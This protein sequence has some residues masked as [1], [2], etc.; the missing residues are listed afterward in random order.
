MP[1]LHFPLTRNGFLLRMAT[2]R[3]QVKRHGRHAWAWAVGLCVLCAGVSIAWGAG[4]SGP[5][6][7]NAAL[8]FV[9]G[10]QDRGTVATVVGIGLATFISEDLACIGSGLLVAQGALSLPLAV[11]ACFVGLYVGDVLLYWAGRLVG[12]PFLR[13]PPFKWLIKQDKVRHCAA[14]LDRRGAAVVFAGRFV[15]GSRFPTFFAAGLLKGH[16][17]RFALYFCLAAAVWTPLLVGGTALAGSAMMRRFTLYSRYSLPLLLGL[18]LIVLLAVRFVVPL[19]THRGRRLLVGFVRSKLYW[20]LWPAWLFNLPV[21]AHCIRLG[22]R[23]GS[24]TAFTAANP[25]IPRSGFVGESKFDIL[26]KLNLPDEFR[27]VTGRIDTD[28]E[29]DERF[30]RARAFMDANGLDYPVV[31]KPDPGHRGIGVRIVRSD[32]RMKETLGA[33]RVAMLVQEFTPGKEFG[34][35]YYRYPGREHGSILSITE[36][37][38]PVVHGDGRRTVEELILDDERAVGMAREY[39]KANFERLED[40]PDAGREVRLLD[41]ANHCRGCMFLDGN[42]LRTPEIEAVFD[43]I[44]RRFDGFYFGRYDVRTT[45]L[46]DFR[47]GRNFKVLELNGVTS[48]ATHIYDRATPLLEAYRTLF[49]QWRIAYEIGGINAADGAEV[50]NLRRLIELSIRDY[51]HSP[52]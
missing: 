8:R 52:E 32:A 47:R 17:P 44:S 25:A 28:V 42:H 5:E 46:E 43:R 15:P 2:G 11:L 6:R 26:T 27:L 38:V 9:D 16:F 22:L 14:W 35:F 19:F 13:V 48:E 4:R 12:N 39:T 33:A 23:R 29:P 7:P 24:L 45:S 50:T 41:V 20:E 34:V 49:E 36:K 1:A 51:I 31:V 18:G 37:V 40:V 3:R 21:V 30:R 10:V